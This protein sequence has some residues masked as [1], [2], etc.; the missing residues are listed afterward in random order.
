MT[1]T[2]HDH[3]LPGTATR[4]AAGTTG[5]RV[6]PGRR[7][8]GGRPPSVHL[9]TPSADPSG[10]GAHMRCLAEEYVRAGRRVTLMYWP[11]A[12][13]E[14]M[15]APAETMGVRLARI[16]HP[17]D[18]GFAAGILED[19][20]R[21]PSDVFHVHVGTGRENFDGARA[22]A[23]AGVPA[24]VQ[25]LHL[26]WLI[27]DHRKRAPALA[28]LEPVDRVITVSHRQR[29]TYERIGVAPERMVTVPNGV[30]PRAVAP[31]RAA[32]RRELGLRPDQPVVMTVG[33]LTVMKGHRYLVAA[34]P[35]VLG[36]VP[37]LVV[38][39]VGAGHLRQALTDQAEQ[40]G[41]AHAVQFVGHRTDARALLDAAD[42]FVLPSRHEGMPLAALEAMD[43]GLPVVGTRVI[44]TSEA[45]EDGIT[46]L[47]VPAARPT[48]LAEA[49]TQLLGDPVRGH[50]M[51]AAG[52]RRYERLF[53]ATRMATATAA[54]YDDVL[55]GATG[56]R[57]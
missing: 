33:R 27:R 3:A 25:T 32:A 15:F 22:A 36:H 21:H 39:V 26:P 4:P 18:P 37:D 5:L 54:V 13:A 17:R 16:P 45:V 9:Y 10:M 12:H 47:L 19:L 6:G 1:T 24:V 38:V 7:A 44:G 43:A 46:G 8:S 11:N 53:T 42:L 57:R 56:R 52:R 14:R 34:A 50:A 48:P 23:A 41:V 35:L 51:A 31:G 55:A 29:L 28:A 20:R 49:L 2:S 40:L 30:Q